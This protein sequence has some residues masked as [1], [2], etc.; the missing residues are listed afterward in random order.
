MEMYLVLAIA[1][2]GNM[3]GVIAFVDFKKE[4]VG[5][6]QKNEDFSFSENNLNIK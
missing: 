3:Y 6:F 5:D 1:I 4:Y 2:V